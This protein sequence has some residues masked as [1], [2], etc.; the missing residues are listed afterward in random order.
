[1]NSSFINKIC[2]ICSDIV[3]DKDIGILCSNDHCLCVGCAKDFLKTTIACGEEMCPAKC[4]VCKTELDYRQVETLLDEDQHCDYS[5]H[6][7]KAL[8][9][10]SKYE[11]VCCPYCRYHEM[12]DLESEGITLFCGYE[13]CK[14]ISCIVCYKEYM[15][16]DDSSG[17]CESESHEKCY[18]L[19]K[20]KKDWDQ[21]TYEGSQRFCPDC[22]YGGI[23][24][25]ACT[26]MSCPQCK[27]EWCY[28]C[29]KSSNI[30]DKSDPEGSLYSHNEEWE[31]NDKRCPMYLSLIGGVDQRWSTR[32]D[33]EAKQFL[34]KILISKAIREFEA[35]YSPNELKEFYETYSEISTN[36]YNIVEARKID[37][38][39][40]IRKPKASKN[41]DKS[42]SKGECIIF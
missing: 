12:W 39:L 27:S 4:S 41:R 19:K 40:I 14:K 21:T 42:T 3:A 11:V 16:A 32:N 34:H 18:R 10:K 13:N 23:K 25:N 20:I 1:M 35:R 37:P 7:T 6:C 17:D 26:H 9:D 29:G 24:D 15:F 31:S 5:L 8:M 30:C 2:I 28:V 38:R 33:A 36:Q 22:K